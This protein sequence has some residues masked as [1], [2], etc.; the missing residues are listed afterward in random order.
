MDI[1][2]DKLDEL[3]AK[4]SGRNDKSSLPPIEKWNPPFSGDLDMR[5]A[6]N[7][8]WYYL[9]SEIKRQALVNLFSTILLYENSEYYL[10]TPVE[11]FR[12]VVDDAPF[13]AVAAERVLQ[14][15]EGHWAFTLNTGEVVIASEQHPINVVHD[16]NTQEPRPYILVR[17]QLKALISRTVFY[18]LV[19]AAEQTED[20]HV[21]I[22]SAGTRFELGRF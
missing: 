3:A 18:Q 17:S 4:L 2:M 22:T 11:K 5:I 19:Q 15:G 20:N 16:P 13:V 7:G 14:D 8:T 1:Q 9:G 10:V 21:I 6:T 12:I